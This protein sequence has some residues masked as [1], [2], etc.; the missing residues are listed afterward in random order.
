MPQIEVPLVGGLFEAR[1]PAVNAQKTVNLYPEVTQSGAKKRIVLY[2][3]PG[4]TPITT[5][6]VGPIRSNM[7]KFDDKLYF[8]SKDELYSLDSAGTAT[9]IGTINTENGRCI[10]AAGRDFLMLVDGTDGWTWD[11]T[12]F[13]QIT[14]TDFE[15]DS[16]GATAIPTHVVYLDGFF[17]VNKAGTDEFAISSLEDPTAWSALDF[18]TASRRPDDVLALQSYDGD[19]YLIGGRT[20]EIFD[21]TG[22]VDFPFERYPNGLIDIGIDAP[23][24]LARG[25]AGLYWLSRTEEGGLQVVHA[26]ALSIRPVSNPSL[27]QQFESLS[28]TDDAIGWV[29]HQAG[30]TFYWL[31]FPAA[32]RTFVLDVGNGLWHERQTGASGRH[33][34]NGH[35]FLAGAHYVGHFETGAIHRLDLDVYT[36]AGDEIFRIRRAPSLHKDRLRMF[37]HSIEVEFEAGVGITTGQGSDPQAMLSLSKDGG[38][39]WTDE[40]WV[41]IGKRGEYKNRAIWRKLGDARQWVTEI[42]VTDPVPVTIIAAYANVE[43][44]GD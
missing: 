20:V 6:G 7:A 26:A 41:P 38:H 14:D 4:L 25:R 43:V 44:A 33:I 2:S 36:D 42:K 21:N 1:S 22:N 15:Q 16:S 32:D 39:T 28:K 18:G 30:H 27:D 29:Y 35:G 17:I 24:S 13:A 40:I 5:A 34:A 12:T 8:V 11:G 9:S 31:T 23:F 10:L 19:L 3:T 37:L